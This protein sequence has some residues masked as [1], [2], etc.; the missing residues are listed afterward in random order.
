MQFHPYSL[1]YLIA[2]SIAGWLAW[3]A[4]LRRSAPGGFSLFTNMLALVVWSGA[5]ACMWASTTLQDQLWWAHISVFGFLLV[6]LSFFTF[7]LNISDNARL[8]NWK[9]FALLFVEPV[10]VLILLWTNESHHL[11]HTTPQLWFEKGLYILKWQP[12]PFLW[13]DVL[14]SYAIILLGIWFL[15]RSLHRGGPLLQSQIQIV[16]AGA[17]LSVLADVFFLFVLSA[18]VKELDISPIVYVA[19]GGVYYYAI[20][21]QGLLDLVPVARSRLVESMTDGVIVVDL[22]DRVVDINP[23][24]QQFLNVTAAQALGGKLS[25]L[26]TRWQETTRPFLDQLEVRTDIAVIHSIERYFELIITP[27][28]DPRKRTVGR[29][30]IFR[31]ISSRKQSEGAL[32]EANNRLREQLDEIRVL[33]DQLHDQATR[34]PLTNLFNRRYLEEFLRQEL[35]RAEREKYPVCLLMV[36]IDRFKRVNDS[37]GHKAGDE[38]LQT[39]AHLLVTHV[40]AFDAVCRYGGEEFLLVMPHL[41]IEVATER[42]E[43]IRREFAN[44]TLPGVPDEIRPT[45]SIGVSSF[46]IH[47]TTGEKLIQAADEALYEAKSNGRNRTVVYSGRLA[48]GNRSERETA[49]RRPVKR[50]DKRGES[51]QG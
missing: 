20:T 15:V 9:L 47:S 4:W 42:A 6:P 44:L 27:L 10:A 5:Y 25:T 22:Q 46:P 19:A 11:I 40:R 28:V 33:R 36:D 38:I 30:V 31:D 45:L 50:T 49:G 8:L 14:Y 2:A 32:R 43:F 39:L 48:G 29:M 21:R 16:L 51:D 24:A 35:A 3:S 7:S 17:I 13:A 1:V 12:G 26:L 23:A 41:S 18:V 34:D 37:C